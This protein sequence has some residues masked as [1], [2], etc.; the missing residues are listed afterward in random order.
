MLMRGTSW[1]EIW[2]SDVSIIYPEWSQVNLK[3]NFC[4]LLLLSFATCNI[5]AETVVTEISF[6]P[7]MWRGNSLQFKWKQKPS[8]SLQA[9]ASFW[10]HIG[11]GTFM[12]KTILIPNPL[13][14]Q[15]LGFKHTETPCTYTSLLFHTPAA[16]REP[17]SMCIVSYHFVEANQ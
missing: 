8:F 15:S 10:G 14:F 17:Q 2:A 16:G 11:K 9:L 3:W 4:Q 13:P 6:F 7:S 5:K 1:E 12:L